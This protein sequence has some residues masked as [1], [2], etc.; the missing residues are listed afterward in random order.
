[1]A[2]GKTLHIATR[3]YH[4]PVENS[5]SNPLAI[6]SVFHLGPDIGVFGLSF[7]PRLGFLHFDDIFDGTKNPLELEVT[8]ADLLMVS[9]HTGDIKS[10][11]DFRIRVGGVS[12]TL[13]LW[14]SKQI[15]GK[16]GG[17][18]YWRTTRYLSESDSSGSFR[19]YRHAPPT[20]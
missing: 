18:V 3:G 1:M 13:P 12:Y 14:F 15:K 6:G 16:N 7:T 17:V 20:F 10:A 2:Q 11:L 4:T 9:G 19:F 5:G 8:N